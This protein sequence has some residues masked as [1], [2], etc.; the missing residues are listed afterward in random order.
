MEL[1]E[2]H[3]MKAIRQEDQA[4]GRPQQLHQE[5]FQLREP[6]MAVVQ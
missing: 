5:W 1:Q 2:T 6:M 3:G 4:E